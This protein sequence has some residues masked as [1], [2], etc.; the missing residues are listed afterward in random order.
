MAIGTAFCVI[1]VLVVV[2]LAS[3]GR[4]S[5]HPRS[6]GTG[7]A[8]RGY[9]LP[10]PAEGDRIAA[11]LQDAVPTAP[12]EAPALPVPTASSTEVEDLPASDPLQASTIAATPAIGALLHAGDGN[13]PEH[14]CTATVVQ[15][16]NRN[17][18]VTAAHCVYS[19]AFT[20]DLAFAPG[21]HDG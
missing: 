2:A 6:R 14:F 21:Y 5:G 9:H 12:P 3:T 18:V 17:L 4:I 15:S 7:D 10:D 13:D 19:D 20:A 8:S 1:A 11:S 16:P